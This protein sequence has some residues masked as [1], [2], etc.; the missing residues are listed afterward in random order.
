MQ[1]NSLAQKLKLIG[2]LKT[3]KPKL[4]PETEWIPENSNL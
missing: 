2:E 3:W 4:L 1:I